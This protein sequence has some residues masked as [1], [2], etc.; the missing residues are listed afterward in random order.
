M[1]KDT[2]TTTLGYQSKTP[3]ELAGILNYPTNRST[4]REILYEMTKEDCQGLRGWLQVLESGLRH[5]NVSAR[6]EISKS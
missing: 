1:V 2:T 4:R 5:M 6:Y 3:D